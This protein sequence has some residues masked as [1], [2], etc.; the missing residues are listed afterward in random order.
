MKKFIQNLFGKRNR[1]TS[2]SATSSSDIN[3]KHNSASNTLLQK[4]YVAFGSCQFD[5]MEK[6]VTEYLLTY[7]KLT[8][9]ETVWFYDRKGDIYDG[10]YCWQSYNLLLLST[11]FSRKFFFA[12]VNGEAAAAEEYKRKAELQAA[13]KV[14]FD[15]GEIVAFDRLL[16]EGA[17]I[18]Y[19]Y[20]APYGDHKVTL[21]QL[22]E[23]RSRM[24][25]YFLTRMDC[26][27]VKEMV[28]KERAE[29][30]L[31]ATRQAKIA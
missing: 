8:G 29:K 30:Q 20:Y 10:V 3:E 24:Y 1:E 25:E 16:S 28:E 21:W 9:E 19:K 4:I 13:L 27:E 18:N 7:G 22:C 31:I 2:L 6:C 12:L 23:K 14:A 26:I 15:K 17:D 11:D 5:E